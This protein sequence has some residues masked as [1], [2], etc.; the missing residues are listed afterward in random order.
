MLVLLILLAYERLL[1]YRD[2]FREAETKTYNYAAVIEARLDSTLRRADATLRELMHEIPVEALS[3]ASLPR[4]ARELNA[5]LDRGMFNFAEVSGI[6]VFDAEGDL[7]YASA[8]EKTPRVNI[9]DRAYFKTARSE[10][11]STLI[12]SSVLT[13]TSTRRLG[14]VAA[15]PLRDTQGQFR[16]VILAVIDLELFQ[17]LFQ[18]MDIGPRGVMV[19][20][21]S[22]DFTAIVRWPV[23]ASEVNRALPPANP[24]RQMLQAGKTEGT[25]TYAA[26]SDGEVRTY[27]YRSVAGYPF[28]VLSAL[29]SDDVL[30]GWRKQTM[31]VGAIA[32]LLVLLI[33]FLLR[34][35]WRTAEREFAAAAQ[36]RGS[37]ERLR[38]ATTA[39]GIGLYDLNVQT[40]KAIVNPEYASML[41]YDPVTFEESNQAWVDRL[42]PDDKEH[43][44]ARYSDYIVGR[45][46]TYI[47]EFRQ[48]TGNGGYKWIQSQGSLVARDAEGKPLRM[49]GTHVDISARKAT[50]QS[51]RDLNARLDFLLSSSPVTLYTSDATP[52]YAAT[53]IS[54]NIE[55]ML[56]YTPHEFLTTPDFWVDRVHPDDR[57]R[58]IAG[59]GDLFLH[60]YHTHTYRFRHHDGSWRH[61]EDAVRLI[62]D[63]KGNPVET[64]GYFVDITARKAAEEAVLTLN[65]QLEQRVKDRTA[66]LEATNKELETFTY[67]VSHDLKAPLRGIDGYSN[68]L[69]QDYADKLDENA[70]QYLR[71]VRKAAQQMGH[72][73]ND[74]LAYSKL[75]RSDVE[76]APVN[77]GDVIGALLDEF[78]HDIGAR[79]AAVTVSANCTAVRA[80]RDGLTMALRNLIGNAL[81]FSQ[82]VSQPQ[83]EI[84]N[85]ETAGAH[86]LWV[87]DNGMGFDMKYHDQIFAIFKR[88]KQGEK[89]PG[90]GVGLAI[91]HK[92][93]SRMGGRA[94][95]ESTPG[96]GATFYLEIPK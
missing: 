74:L 8:S 72:L 71:N 75:E 45:S 69:L 7:L 64:L 80:D 2:A 50:E 83:I 11:T 67:S 55:A 26:S 12:F 37:E 60:G 42:H 61:M 5:T 59:L 77:P 23:L 31:A 9:A 34:Q 58:V 13:I 3:Q 63:D 88:L 33:A 91:V 22:D 39:G 19:I 62:K 41:G 40:G 6:R 93:M 16:G 73:I 70:K 17:K 90:T 28:F 36:L 46:P 18:T 49:L 79:H 96:M 68:L 52:P 85:S 35:L 25:V 51:L 86:L 82:D 20:R 56:G 87:R 4:Y 89:Y 47:V 78:A 94:W 76:L 44:F 43:T 15:R 65:A 57:E 66:E 1:S 95:A 32:A 53:F 38:L 14:I 81:K 27:S 54:D 29:A 92:A 48:R 10:P 30:A 24:V 84:G 21:R